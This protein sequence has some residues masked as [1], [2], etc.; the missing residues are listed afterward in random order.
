MPEPQRC[1]L[2]S[3]PPLS[4]SCR[5]RSKS[6]GIFK[7]VITSR[8]P[9]IV[10]LG[11]F[12]LGVVL[13]TAVFAGLE[14]AEQT[15]IDDL[16]QRQADNQFA[17]FRSALLRYQDQLDSVRT[18]LAFAGP[19]SRVQFRESAEELMANFPAI[20]EVEWIP[21]VAGTDRE[22]IEAQVRADGFSDFVFRDLAASGPVSLVPSQSAGEY[23]PV[24]Y[25]EP[26]ARARDALG[27]NV[28][29]GRSAPQANR[30]RTTGLPSLSQ[31]VRLLTGSDNAPGFGLYLPV[32]RRSALPTGATRE[33]T[34]MVLGLFRA[35]ELLHEAK[36]LRTS[37]GWFDLQV[38]DQTDPQR[39]ALLGR[40]TAAGE[41]QFD[42]PDT[43][44]VGPDTIR[45]TAQL[46]G[47]TWE[48]TYAPHRG[49]PGLPRAQ[50]PTGVLLVGLIASLAF[51]LLGHA[52]SDHTVKIEREVI[53][54]TAELT[55]S[56]ALLRA[57][58]AERAQVFERI[59]DAFVALD[60][61]WRYTYVNAKA[62]AMLGRRPEDL[63]G[64]HI[65]TEFPEGVGQA[66]HAT[67]EKAMAE[68][69]PIFMEEHYPP[70]NKWFENRIYPSPEG[71]SIYFYDISN[72]KLAESERTRLWNVLEASLNEIYI[73][74]GET[75]R[76]EYV[77]ECARR[78]LGYSME[79]M[80]AMTPVSIKPEYNEPTFNKLVGPL[81]RHEQKK[82]TFETIHRR[83]DGSDYPVEV[84]LQLVER[85]E[86]TVFLAV[87][88]DIT[89]RKRIET[90]LLASRE[91]L[92][93]LMARQQQARDDERIR[94]SRDI[95]DELGQL[96]TGLKMDTRWLE[97]KLSEPGLPPALNRLL[98]RAVGASE[99]ADA[100]IAS[101]QKIAAEL[102]P[103][104]LSTLGLSDS[105]RQEA[106][107]FAARAGL[108]CSVVVAESGA[109]APP[110]VATELFHICR[111]ALTNVA[112][113]AHAA[114]VEIHL[115]AEADGIMLEVRDDGVGLAEG[116]TEARQSLG[117]LGMRE[118]AAQ[119]GGTV[120]FTR[121]EPRGTRVTVRIPNQTDAK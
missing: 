98:D 28:L 84:H 121:N 81:R 103:G 20:Q 113:H 17:A 36:R 48:F 21:L 56:Q 53:T 86:R 22:R 75:L 7:P 27:F 78:N 41:V 34:G 79:T 87:I 32:F 5:G 102:R 106:R 64:K 105:L 61:N 54:R 29:S 116:S 77:N 8:T 38:V 6:T 99:L 85:D 50:Q 14:R 93:A 95:H 4:K 70:Y 18:L 55:R 117:V 73:F 57:S 90:E 68:Q 37:Q 25:A 76:F 44:A 60:R 62:G 26:V 91:Q 16:L 11:I 96:L 71:V 31:P 100:A 43:P 13:S 72:R 67:Y 80:R 33:F 51:G 52:R 12:G 58:S 107:E 63:V 101:V 94:I 89:V 42:Q 104:P 82:L 24:I 120:A 9:T 109:E 59:T 1:Y 40:V 3:G 115:Q 65:W 111:E 112:R 74:D 15:R 83:A 45:Q 69:Q 10:G 30:A 88:N 92:R 35:D 119:H 23:L 19:V 66:F 108:R 46:W 114:S 110:E 2:S 47:R 118:R 39:P 97:R 49:A